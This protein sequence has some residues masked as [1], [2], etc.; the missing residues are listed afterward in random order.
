M[1]VLWVRDIFAPQ[2][3]EVDFPFYLLEGRREI[4]SYLQQANSGHLPIIFSVKIL[5]QYSLNMSNN[6]ATTTYIGIVYYACENYI[7]TQA[8]T[9]CRVTVCVPVL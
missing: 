1:A 6:Y 2:Q 8:K 5:A 4:T 7:H 3:R 9:G